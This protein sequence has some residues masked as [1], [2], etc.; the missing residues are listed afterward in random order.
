LIDEVSEAALEAIEQAAGEAAQVATLASLEREAAAYREADRWRVQAEINEL[1]V[2]Q[3]KKAGVKN[4]VIAGLICL[5]SGFV[6]G[7]TINR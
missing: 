3:A 7:M 4:A 2:K 6:V 5:I 1:T